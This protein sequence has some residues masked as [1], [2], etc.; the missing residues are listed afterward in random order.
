MNQLRLGLASCGYLGLVPV[1][2]GTFGT[3]GGVLIAWALADTTYFGLW[4]LLAAGVVYWVGRVLGDWA[5]SWAGRKDPGWFVLDEVA[6]YLVTVAWF[7]GPSPLAL[8]TAFCAFRFFDI[9]K[10][11][12]VRRF[13]RIGGGDGIMLDDV[14]AGLYGLVLVMLPLRLLVDA[15]WSTAAGS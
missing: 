11:P 9:T 15:P 10:P 5:E 7:S 12:P 8:L 14:V 13:E 1:A 2:P 6:G 3:L 4:V